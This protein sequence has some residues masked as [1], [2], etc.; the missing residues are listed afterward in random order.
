[1]STSTKYARYN[2]FATRTASAGSR[3]LSHRTIRAGACDEIGN[4]DGIRKS[5]PWKRAL[6]AKSRF[7][8]SPLSGIIVSGAIAVSLKITPRST[9]CQSTDR[10]YLPA[11]APIFCDARKP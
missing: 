3:A 5:T 8:Y 9:G 10:P 6:R 7:E 1:M 4:F 2:A 11:S